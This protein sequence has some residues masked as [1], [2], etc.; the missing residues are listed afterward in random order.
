MKKDKRSKHTYPCRSASGNKKQMYLTERAL[1]KWRSNWYRH[2]NRMG[3]NQHGAVIKLRCCQLEHLHSSHYK[4]ISSW[5]HLS[6]FWNWIK[7]PSNTIT[8]VWVMHI[9]GAV[10]QPP[11]YTHK[12]T[13][14]NGIC[15]NLMDH[16]NLCQCLHKHKHE[17][18]LTRSGSVFF[19]R[20]LQW[21]GPIH[22]GVA[23]TE[24]WVGY[25]EEGV[26]SGRGICGQILSRSHLFYTIL[27]YKLSNT[28]FQYFQNWL[29]NS[30]NTVI[31]FSTSYYILYYIIC[32]GL[33]VET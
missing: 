22:E 33:G 14:L 31:S 8:S 3:F 25:I 27:Q 24:K 28:S 16:W 20:F 21:V 19:N 18:I 23:Y 30:A 5:G 6:F 15:A 1:T 7:S 9:C 29:Q 11:P 17:H 10:Y 32:T 13:F 4:L 12:H 26:V 2:A